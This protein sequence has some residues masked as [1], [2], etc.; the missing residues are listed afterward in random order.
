MHKVDIMKLNVTQRWNATFDFYIS[1]L[2]MIVVHDEKD[3]NIF[4]FEML[5]MEETTSSDFVPPSS[6]RKLSA[7]GNSYIA[8]LP[9]QYEK[10]P[11]NEEED[12]NLDVLDVTNLNSGIIAFKFTS[13]NFFWK[14]GHKSICQHTNKYK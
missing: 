1:Q 14:G 4:K 7:F 12:M 2:E 3:E 5:P 6:K 11:E 9:K 13:D 10:V 8:Y